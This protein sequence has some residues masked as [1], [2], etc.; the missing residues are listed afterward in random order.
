LSQLSPHGLARRVIAIQ[1]T[2]GLSIQEAVDIS[3]LTVDQIK[4]ARSNLQE[5]DLSL[6]K[7]NVGTSFSY[8]IRE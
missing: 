7:M 2:N 4:K 8:Y 5:I 6:L 3:G 1:L